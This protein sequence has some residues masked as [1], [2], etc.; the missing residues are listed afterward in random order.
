MSGNL[1]GRY[2]G[3]ITES[4]VGVWDSGLPFWS[5]VVDVTEKYN[6]STSLWET[7]REKASFDGRLTLYSKEG[8]ECFAV[9][10]AIAVIGWTG[11]FN[12]FNSDKIPG[13]PVQVGVKHEADPKGILRVNVAG[14]YLPDSNP[15]RSLKALEP[16]AIAE[17]NAKYSKLSKPAT[18]TPKPTVDVADARAKLAAEQAAALN[19]TRVDLTGNPSTPPQQA[20]A[21]SAVVNT[22]ESTARTVTLE[23]AP[24]PS[25]SNN[26]FTLTAEQILTYNGL[27]LKQAKEKA[28]AAYQK[29]YPQPKDA[30]LTFM[31]NENTVFHGVVESKRD[32][33]DYAKVEA[34]A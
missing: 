8:K 30:A 22:M 18:V 6:E 23:A 24:T 19:K 28:F 17:L 29:K 16:S 4:Q 26:Y 34:L 15:S 12:E 1:A 14:V 25:P 7:L 9:S 3:V 33:L 21:P 31:K 5:V 20:S 11:D 32:I 10:Q 13:T 27:T 2:K